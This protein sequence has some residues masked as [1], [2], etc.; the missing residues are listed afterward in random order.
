MQNILFSTYL[1]QLPHLDN[2]RLNFNATIFMAATNLAWES[3][4]HNFD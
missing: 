4:D 3:R 1:N 2:A